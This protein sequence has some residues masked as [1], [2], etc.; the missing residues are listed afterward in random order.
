MLRSKK[1][2][3]VILVVG[4]AIL[5]GTTWA[6]AQDNNIIYACA[7]TKDGSVR[8]VA[9]SGQCRDK[10]TPLQ[11]NIT[12]PTG[13]QGPQGEQGIQGEQGPIGPTGPQGPQGEQGPPGVSGYEVIQVSC[14]ALC[15]TTPKQC[16]AECPTGKAVLGG[17]FNGISDSSSNHP[18][19]DGTGWVVT[20]PWNLEFE[21]YASDIFW[22]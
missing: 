3:V 14:P 4:I 17:G 21:A 8:V 19:S 12:G 18:T 2:M 10:E 13:P 15:C 7:N 9:L 1:F 22:G 20:G 5:I 16:I 11:W 6:F